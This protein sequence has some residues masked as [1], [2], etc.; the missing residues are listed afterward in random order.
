MKRIKG[1]TGKDTEREVYRLSKWQDYS[2]V[3]VEKDIFRNNFSI[4]VSPR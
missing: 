4:P 1:G 2:H 3:I